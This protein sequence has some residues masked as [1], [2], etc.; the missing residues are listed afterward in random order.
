LGDVPDI[1]T[2]VAEQADDHLRDLGM[3][4]LF[5]ETKVPTLTLTSQELHSSMVL[6][7]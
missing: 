1:E 5:M 3:L 2:M 7:S 6:T 4:H